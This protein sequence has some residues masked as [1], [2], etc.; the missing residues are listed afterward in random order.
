MTT[1][2]YLSR[3]KRWIVAVSYVGFG[4]FIIG[5]LLGW[6]V[7]GQPIL[8]ISLPGF[9]IAACGA[10]GQLLL[11]QCP[12]CKGHLYALAMHGGLWAVSKNVR[13]CPYCG[14]GFD[15]PLPSAEPADCSN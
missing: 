11:L 3:R 15:D 7:G 9:A 4:L 10:V 13:Y 2:A 6:A 8:A 5:I 14:I 12:A 1:R